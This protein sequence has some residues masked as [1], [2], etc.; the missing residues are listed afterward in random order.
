[1][2]FQDASTRDNVPSLPRPKRATINGRCRGMSRPARLVRGRRLT[3]MT[4]EIAP[5][6]TRPTPPTGRGLIPKTD[7]N[8]GDGGARRAK[9]G[10]TRQPQGETMNQYDAHCRRPGCNC[11]HTICYQGW[12]DHEYSTTP[13]AYCRPTTFERWHARENARSK[14]YP[15]ESLGRIMRGDR[16]P[17]PTPTHT[18][19]PTPR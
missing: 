3:G 16:T 13:C 19:T 1:M 17:T 15:N 2:R 10:R 4:E 12:R 8:S 7:H 18:Y 6:S 5:V 14:G 11:E 9:L